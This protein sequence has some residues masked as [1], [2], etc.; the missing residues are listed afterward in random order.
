MIPNKL[1]ATRKK[2]K[3]S[4]C[5]LSKKSNVSRVTISA[6]ERGLNQQ[7]TTDTLEKLSAALNVPV[8]KIFFTS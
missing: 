5:E 7:L 4:Q 8:R 3:L 2:A 6:I 1:K